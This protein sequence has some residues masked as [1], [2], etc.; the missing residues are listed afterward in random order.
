MANDLL[1]KNADLYKRGRYDLIAYKDLQA[2]EV[3]RLHPKQ[4]Q[5]LEYFNDGKAKYIGYGG[6]A[7]GG[8]TVLGDLA[9]LLECYAYPGTRYLLAR[10]ELINMWQTTWKTMMRLFANFD[11]KKDVDFTHNQQRHEVKFL[12]T[13]SEII[14][15]DARFEPSDPDITRL[16]SMEVTKAFIDQSEQVDARVV[17]KIGER[18]GTHQNLKYNLKGKVLESFN[19]AHTH[20]YRRYYKPWKA[21]TET[22]NRKFVRALPA[23]NPGAEAQRWVQEKLI[24]Y[25]AG[26]MSEIEYQRQ[27]LGNFEYDT[28]PSILIE[29]DALL[30]IVTNAHVQPDRENRYITADIAL[31]GSDRFMVAVWYGWVCVEVV[32]MEKSGGKQIVD[33]I[34]KLMAKHAVFGSR[35]IYDSD[36]VGGFIGSRGGFI[37]AAKAFHGGAAPFK[38]RGRPENYENLKAQCSYEVAKVINARKIYIPESALPRPAQH[39]SEMLVED[40]NAAI[41]GRDMDKDGKLCLKKKEDVKRDLGRSPE[42]ADIVLMRQYVELMPKPKPRRAAGV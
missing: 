28:D 31:Q 41:R 4:I 22:D 9:I 25:A 15:F 2:D 19:P 6:S 24:D 39:E 30:D 32:V 23:D 26:D 7:R 1:R 20:V 10:K 8:K 12:E 36:G 27:I 14:L 21:R 40:L 33:L 16:G 37:P 17:E 42:Y 35:V 38:R 13:G 3:V 11:I 18:V 5:A 29:Y 34:R